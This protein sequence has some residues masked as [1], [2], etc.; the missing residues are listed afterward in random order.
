M[1]YILRLLGPGLPLGLGV[2]SGSVACV[3]AGA[4]LFVPGFGPGTP[5]RLPSLLVAASPSSSPVA[6]GVPLDL[7]PFSSDDVFEA[8]GVSKLEDCDGFDLT[9]LTSG[10]GSESS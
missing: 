9:G 4:D 1:T 6:M 10:F 8:F 2:P 7:S 5:F 3:G